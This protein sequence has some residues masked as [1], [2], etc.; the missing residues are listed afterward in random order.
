MPE[1]LTTNTFS[2][3]EASLPTLRAVLKSN[4]TIIM[5]RHR[6]NRDFRKVLH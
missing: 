3:C 5:W 1:Y 2:I 4:G 6:D